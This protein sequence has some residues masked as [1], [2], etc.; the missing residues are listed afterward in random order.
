E[1]EQSFHGDQLPTSLKRKRREDS[2]PSLALR[3]C[4]ITPP[5]PALPPRLPPS[6]P[7]RLGPAAAPCPPSAPPRPRPES[8]S[9]SR[10]APNG[11]ASARPTISPPA[12]WRCP[13]PRCPGRS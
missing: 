3:A 8:P 6:S 12:G 1:Y 5:P 9:R 2:H 7:C 10:P 4:H 11:S 13:C